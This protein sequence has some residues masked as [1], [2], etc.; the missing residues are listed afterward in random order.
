[1]TDKPFRFHDLGQR[2]GTEIDRASPRLLAAFLFY[3]LALIF[4]LT[5]L[6][7]IGGDS[8]PTVYLPV[9]ILRWGTFRLDPLMGQVPVLFN[10]EKPPSYLTQIDGHFYSKFSPFPALLSI[11]V[12]AIYMLVGPPENYAV[13]L[14]LSRLMS[15]L[16]S[17][18]TAITVFYLLRIILPQRRALFLTFVY[19]LATFAWPMA[20]NTFATQSTGEMFLALAVLMLAKISMQPSPEA[21][22]AVPVKLYALA[23]FFASLALISRPQT[24]PAA[25]LLSI[26]LLQFTGRRWRALFA[27]GIAATPAAVFLAAY[28]TWAFGAPW[29]T[30]Y[31]GEALFGWSYPL[32]KGLP[33]IL[34]SPSHGLLM[35]S[36]VMLLAFVGGWIVWRR[37]GKALPQWALGRYLA[38]ISLLQLFLMSGWHYWN[39]GNAY[40]QRMLHEVTPLIVLLIG[41]AWHQYA[42]SRLFSLALAATT[43]WGIWMNVVR[44]AF[45]DQHI[46]WSE[47][48]RPEIDWSLAFSELAMYIH[49]H[50]LAGMLAGAGQVALMVGGLLLALTVVM[51]RFVMVSN[52]KQSAG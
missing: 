22:N 32:W 24:L 8:P 33:G 52:A 35:Y 19:A 10:P 40:N 7:L 21:P 20:T 47:I 41:L 28:N 46:F 4:L 16:V 2:I 11:P 23:G 27:Y 6:D 1:M 37:S 50:G 17:T 30:G 18:V 26:Y 29:R 42:P 5:Q 15:V 13:Y 45:Y 43:A 25:L 51:I 44:V 39:G 9:S 38:A 34:I 36:P 14:T 31:Q 48:Y 49:W 3:T 12:Y